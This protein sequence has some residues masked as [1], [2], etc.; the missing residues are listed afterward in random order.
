MD[1]GDTRSVDVLEA[2][3][4]HNTYKILKLVSMKR[5]GYTIEQLS[6]VLKLTKK[7]LYFRIK[8]L[9]KTGLVKRQNDMISTTILGNSVMNSMRQVHDALRIRI[10]LKAI[11]TFALSG[12]NSRREIN[13]LIDAMIED[14]TIRK[15]IKGVP[16]G[17]Q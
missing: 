9:A 14:G 2:I 5:D 16:T 1:T 6:K 3:S 4:D 10:Q 12:G 17:V 7:Q 13:L 8:K 11:D 15:M